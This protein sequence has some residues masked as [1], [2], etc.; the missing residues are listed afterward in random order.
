MGKNATSNFEAQKKVRAVWSNP[1]FKTTFCDLCV[2]DILKG[3][4]A[5]GTFSKDGWIKLLLNLK[6]R[7]GKGYD[8]GQL[9][10]KWDGLKA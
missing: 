1:S 7:T 10:N 8:R 6:T 4:R 9:K 2:N 5:K 3:N